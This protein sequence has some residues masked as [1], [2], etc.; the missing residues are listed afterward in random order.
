MYFV[1]KPFLPARVK[2]FL[3]RLDVAAKRAAYTKVWPIDEAAAKATPQNWKGW[4][5]GKKFAIVLTHDVESSLG[6]QRCLKL[7]ELEQKLGFRSSFNFIARQYEV[8]MALQSQLRK[9][10]F[11]IGLHGLVHNGDPFKSRRIFEKQAVEI[12]SYLKEWDVAGFRCPSMYHNLDWIGE[13]KIQYDSSTFDTDPFEPQPDGVGTIFPFWVQSWGKAEGYVELPYTLPQDHSVFVLM[14]EE[15]IAIWKRKLDWIAEKGGMALLITHPDYMNFNGERGGNEY[16]VQLYEEFLDYIKT[17]Y[18]GLYWHALPKEVSRFWTENYTEAKH[19]NTVPLNGGSNGNGKNGG[20]GRSERKK[21]WIDLDNSPHVPFFSPIIK[22]LEKKDYQVLLT[23]RDCSQTCDLADLFHMEYR[24]IGRHYGKKKILKVAGTVFRALQLLPEMR[25]S[26]PALAVS[27]GSRAQMLAAWMLGIPSIVIMDYEHVTGL[28]FLHPTWVMMPEVIAGNGVKEDREK[29]IPYPGIKEDVYV[30]TFKPDP[31]L[32][33]E[34]GIRADDLMVTIRPPATEAHY[35]NPEAEVL[36]S[37]AVNLLGGVQDA[38]MVI[39]PRYAEQEDW[40][41]REW[42]EWCE[43][44]K[45]VIPKQ[46][47]DGLNLLW[48]SDFVISGGGTMNRE[49]AALGVPVYS[50]FRG[51]IGAVDRYLAKNGRLILLESVEDVHKKLSITRR[52]RSSSP[53]NGNG[54]TLTCVMEGIVGVL[55]N[56]EKTGTRIKEQG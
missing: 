36:F 11:E 52:A 4:P 25:K 5:D 56:G 10:R 23:T 39:L 46:V 35:H 8:S 40:I 44:G 42:A 27:H 7:A 2:L 41:R 51:K 22:E 1:M 16:P 48:N 38:R 43:I 54:K 50:I 15:S 6:Q 31:G 37:A 9:M 28:G 19:P 45:I 30:P 20:S 53:K 12:N 24:R 17:R 29:I 49:A 21:V 26:K 34:L 13:L 32:R 18:K 47:V 33:E 14:Q 3:R 55:E